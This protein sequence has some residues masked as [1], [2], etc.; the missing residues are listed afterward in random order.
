MADNKTGVKEKFQNVESIQDDIT[1][2][3]I[4][5]IIGRK[6]KLIAITMIATTLLGLT[7]TLL[8]PHLY[9]A[10]VT[11]MVS[12]GQT[13]SLEKLGNDEISRNQ[14][15]VSTYAEIARSKSIML[16][17]IRNL[18]LEMSPEEISKLLRMSPVEETELI[19]ITYRDKNP[20]K[21][22]MLANEISEEFIQ[23]ISD[24]MTFENLKIVERATIPEKS[25]SDMKI[26]VGIVSIILGTLLGVFLAIV[27]EFLY[28]KLRKPEDIER[29]MGC[30]ILANLPKYNDSEE[31]DHN[32]T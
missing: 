27:S 32:G 19:K 9:E 3:E 12:N 20:Q 7:V 18:D 15:L 31:G 25:L 13:Y 26:V 28:G 16:N 11:L 21:A 17:V 23:K 6:W 8:R 29:I 24:V 14:R 10:E 2:M 30:Q 22:A 5:F 4:L 1:L